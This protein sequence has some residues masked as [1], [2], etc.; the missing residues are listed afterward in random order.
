MVGRHRGSQRFARLV[1]PLRHLTGFRVEAVYSPAVARE[2]AKP[3]VVNGEQRH[4]R[5]WE[6]REEAER[7]LQRHPVTAPKRKGGGAPK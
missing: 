6:S 1:V 5:Q 3:W 7:V 2:L 4:L